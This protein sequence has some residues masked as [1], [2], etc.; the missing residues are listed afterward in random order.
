MVNGDI[1]QPDPQAQ[2][3]GHGPGCHGPNRPSLFV[4]YLISMAGYAFV[5][6]LKAYKLSLH[7][8][9]FLFFQVGG[10]GKV[11]REFGD[12]AQAGLKGLGGMV[13]VVAIEAK[14]LFQAQRVACAQANG[15]NAFPF[16]GI[17]YGVPYFFRIVLVHIHLKPARAS[18]PGIAQDHVLCPGKPPN[19]KVVEFDGVLIYAFLP[20]VH[21]ALYLSRQQPNGNCWE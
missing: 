16:A 2:H 18:V 7:P 15:L 1:P 4:F 20:L 5:H 8:L 3:G 13:D 19:G 21:R 10:I 17:K 6:H 9:L 12:P 11:L 14:S